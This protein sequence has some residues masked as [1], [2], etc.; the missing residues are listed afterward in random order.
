MK[1]ITPSVF[2]SLFV[3]S[4]FS[5]HK[6]SDYHHS[7][8]FRLPVAEDELCKCWVSKFKR[9]EKVVHVRNGDLVYRHPLCCL[10]SSFTCRHLP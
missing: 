2:S 10:L 9:E 6:D 5:Y 1:E 8:V 4:L 3:F 7:K